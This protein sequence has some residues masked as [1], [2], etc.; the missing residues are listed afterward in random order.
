MLFFDKDALFV[1]QS[2][3]YYRI[4]MVDNYTLVRYANIF[5][6]HGFG[7]IQFIFQKSFKI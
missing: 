4:D 5:N 6:V 7:K 2:P 3:Q 1:D